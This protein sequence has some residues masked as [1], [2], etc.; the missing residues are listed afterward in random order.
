MLTFTD[1][2]MEWAMTT[3]FVVYYGVAVYYIGNML[4]HQ[5]FMTL[6]P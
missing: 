2:L 4:S 1:K 6:L 3:L 5:Y